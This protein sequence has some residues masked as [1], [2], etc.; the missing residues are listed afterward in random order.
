MAQLQSTNV[1]GV[2][3]VNGVA[4]GG[5][6]DFK[7]CCITSTGTWTPSSDLVGGDG[8]VQALLVGGGGQGGDVGAYRSS[9]AQGV[10]KPGGGGGGEVREFMYPVT[11]SET[12]ATTIGAGGCRAVFTYEGAPA[13]CDTKGPDGGATCINGVELCIARGG[14][15]GSGALCV[16]AP[17]GVV[18]CQRDASKNGGDYCQIGGGHNEANA[19][20][21]NYFGYAKWCGVDQDGYNNTSGTCIYMENSDFSGS[22]GSKACGNTCKKYNRGYKTLGDNFGA[23]GGAC[24]DDTCIPEYLIPDICCAFLNTKAAPA[25]CC[26]QGGARLLVS[27]CMICPHMTQGGAGGNGLIVLQW[28]E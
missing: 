28:N 27:G 26:G 20:I 7:Y 5:G 4:V 17:S 18:C 25:T 16:S 15:G 22:Y 6:K 12:H 13:E 14:G 3:C 24:L 11:S 1:T 8:V 23:G 2:L 21:P 19:C 10:A 9:C